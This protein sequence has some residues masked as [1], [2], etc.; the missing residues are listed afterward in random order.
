M[1]ITPKLNIRLSVNQ[2]FEEI[3]GKLKKAGKGNHNSNISGIG[4]EKNA[5]SSS[6]Y[7]LVT[8]LTRSI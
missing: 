1:D 7:T 8:V 3:F 4:E 6:E 2:R 5:G